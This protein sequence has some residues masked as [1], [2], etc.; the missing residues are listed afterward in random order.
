MGVHSTNPL[1]LLTEKCTPTK[2]H[3][4]HTR[5]HIP[6]KR[7]T[8]TEG[9]HPTITDRQAASQSIVDPSPARSLAGNLKIKAHRLG[10]L[11][12]IATHDMRASGRG[13][14]QVSSTNILS[15]G[16]VALASHRARRRQQAIAERF[17]ARLCQG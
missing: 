2:Q 14:P 8:F 17:V 9:L 10:P 5:S 16:L 13:T 15:Q 7:P 3:D 1:A 4:T 6:S 12:S 11:A